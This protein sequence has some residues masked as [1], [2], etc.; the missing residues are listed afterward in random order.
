M[1]FRLPALVLSFLLLVTPAFSFDW[2]PVVTRVEK[3]VV[4]I[5]HIT[6]EEHLSIAS[7][8]QAAC[9]G[10]SI[11]RAKG[12]FLTA[13]H[14]KGEEMRINR[15]TAWM[16]YESVAEDLMVLSAAVVRKPAL[17]PSTQHMTRG[18]E[19]FSLGYA[20]GLDE[21]LFRFGHVSHPGMKLDYGMAYGKGTFF[22]IDITSI[23]GMSG[24]PVLD[25]EG[26]VVSIIQL[27]DGMSGLGRP[28]GVILAHTGQYW[29]R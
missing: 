3:S 21:P 10:F 28:I 9:T 6:A 20:Y 12:Y 1:I 11:N 23:G 29:E 5:S 26:K 15:S 24:G 27:G 7:G 13:S 4:Q 25:A 16:L 14:C 18:M 19:V 17:R 22:I 8:M 2:G